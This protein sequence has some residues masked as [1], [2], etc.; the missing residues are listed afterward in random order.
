MVT[1]IS[2][3]SM[4]NAN[5]VLKAMSKKKENPG[6]EVRP[7]SS[8]KR[9]EHNLVPRPSPLFYIYIGLL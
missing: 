7:I 3:F 6:D 5:L 4:L 8:K 2:Y 9:F 1:W